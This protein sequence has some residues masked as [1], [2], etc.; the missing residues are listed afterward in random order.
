MEIALV[1][2]GLIALVGIGLAL[3]NNSNQKR[4]R[5]EDRL[6]RLPASERDRL[7]KK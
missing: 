3:T 1:A 5:L 2:F 6:M 7:L 4:K